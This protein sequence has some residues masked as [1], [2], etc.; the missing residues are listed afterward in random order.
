LRLLHTISTRVTNIC[1][2]LSSSMEFSHHYKRHTNLSSSHYFP[3]WAVFKNF[4]V[5]QSLSRSLKSENKF[6]QKIL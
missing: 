2:R 6:S 5:H 4:R 3:I 1:R